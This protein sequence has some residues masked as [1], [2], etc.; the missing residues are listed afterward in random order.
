MELEN[1]IKIFASETLLSKQQNTENSSRDIPN[2]GNS[3]SSNLTFPQQ[4]LNLLYGDKPWICTSNKLY[5]WAGTHYQHSPDSIER[6]RIADFCNSFVVD[7]KKVGVAFPYAKPASVS[8]ALQWAKYC[9]EVNSEL[10]NPQGYF[11]LK[12]CLSVSN[13]NEHNR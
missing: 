4:A 1:N 11:I 9:F 10:I 13:P 12:S 7:T 3:A 8:E 6:C 5:Y 2:S